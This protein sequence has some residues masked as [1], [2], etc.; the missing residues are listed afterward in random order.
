[1]T[2]FVAS[3]IGQANFIDGKVASASG[4]KSVLMAGALKIVRQLPE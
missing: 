1:M 4:N 3:F 2:R